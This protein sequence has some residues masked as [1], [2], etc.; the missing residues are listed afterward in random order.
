MDKYYIGETKNKVARYTISSGNN[1]INSVSGVSDPAFV[2]FLTS[3]YVDSSDSNT[4][5]RIVNYIIEK[6][7]IEGDFSIIL[8]NQMKYGVRIVI[9]M[10]DS[11]KLYEAIV[12]SDN[13]SPQLL[14]WR[15]ISSITD[16]DPEAFSQYYRI[17]SD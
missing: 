11:H 3:S 14:L 1:L 9:Q 15:R 7:K 10:N 13:K 6:V 16:V 8:V 12:T 17:D 5:D 2:P 4:I